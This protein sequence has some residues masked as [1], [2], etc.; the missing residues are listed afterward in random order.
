MI[1]K[2]TILFAALLISISVKSQEQGKSYNDGHGK[3]VFL[4]LGDISFADQVVKFTKG[5]PAAI[6]ISSNSEDA[7]KSPDFDG[8]T[9]GFVSLGCGGTL[10]LKFTDNALI[11][12]E[13]PDLYVF[14][15]GK[16]IE[17]TELSISK[18][19]LEWIAIGEIAGAKAEVDIEAFTQPFDVF[20]YVRLVDLKTSCKGQWP[21]ADI[22]AVAA[23]GAAKR[24]SFTGSVLFN[25]NESELKPDAKKMLED[26]I[27][28][29]DKTPLANILVEGYTD[30]LGTKEFNKNLSLARAEA[31][32]NVLRKKLSDKSYTI[33][34]RGL[35]ASNPL[36][37][38][39][40][41]EGQEKNRRVEI[42]LIP[43]KK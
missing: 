19:G 11:N 28:E 18:N 23:I 25:F 41:K 42:I 38:N 37:S 14:E 32:K 8:G 40:T 21:G 4:P 12:R 22:D 15:M 30:S 6:E 16:Y 39:N 35:G 7:L 29:I 20:N 10:I 26:L 2:T 36:F 3:E 17:S 33:D 13:G 24:I 27:K 1:Y 5:E 43:V 31:V 9:E 34:A